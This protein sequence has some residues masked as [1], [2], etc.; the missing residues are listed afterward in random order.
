MSSSNANNDFSVSTIK[1][2][3]NTRRARSTSNYSD[4]RADF[5]KVVNAGLSTAG[6]V[7]G[8]VSPA[9]ANAITGAVSLARG[10]ATGGSNTAQGANAGGLSAGTG[11]SVGMG[12]GGGGG[13]L[14]LS[15][16]H[17]GSTFGGL[18]NEFAGIDANLQFSSSMNLRFLQIQ[19][20]M[21]QENRVYAAL[22]N[23]IKTRHDTAKAM[24]QNVRA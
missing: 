15:G 12:S 13:T 23:V 21:Q 7:A 16:L 20:M 22:S 8:F 14:A 3:V 17:T 10:A 18:D 9:A 2:E 24:I 1:A 11:V 4:V 5:A 6:Q 19:M